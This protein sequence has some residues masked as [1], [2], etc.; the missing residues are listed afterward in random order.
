MMLIEGKRSLML[1]I[2]G[3][4]AITVKTILVVLTLS[5]YLLL[6]YGVNRKKAM[7]TS[8]SRLQ[9]HRTI[10]LQALPISAYSFVS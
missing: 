8:A 7:I 6:L 3:Y 4:I 10:V 5:G 9:S 2:S 1:D